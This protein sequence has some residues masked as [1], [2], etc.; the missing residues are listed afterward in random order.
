MKIK[1]RKKKSLVGWMEKANWNNLSHIYRD[2]EKVRT[3][4]IICKYK[5]WWMEPVKVKLTIEEL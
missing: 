5:K 2:Y 3:E 4:T 1:S